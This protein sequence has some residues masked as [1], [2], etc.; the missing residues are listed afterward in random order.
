M[1]EIVKAFE[2]LQQNVQQHIA[3]WPDAVLMVA[4][5]SAAAFLTILAFTPGHRIFKAVVLAYV[6]LP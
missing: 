1:E 2:A 3:Q 5:L 6:V 4:L